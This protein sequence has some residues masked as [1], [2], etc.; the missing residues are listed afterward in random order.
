MQP[1]RHTPPVTV[2]EPG[3][4]QQAVWF[5]VVCEWVPG[6][7]QPCCLHDCVSV[8]LTFIGLQGHGA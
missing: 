7:L 3:W 4:V 5:G 6:H 2:G 8:F 1:G